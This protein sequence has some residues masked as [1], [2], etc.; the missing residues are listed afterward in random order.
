MGSKFAAG[1][2]SQHTFLRKALQVPAE[3]DV[4]QEKANSCPPVASKV[5]MANVMAQEGGS[6]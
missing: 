6:G 5:L 4:R 1:L 3:D 2:S